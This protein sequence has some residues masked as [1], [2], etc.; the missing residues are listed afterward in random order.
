MQYITVRDFAN[1][2][3]QSLGGVYLL[4]NTALSDYGG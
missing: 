1:L 2:G 3:L 4:E